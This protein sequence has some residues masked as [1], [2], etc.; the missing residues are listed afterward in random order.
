MISSKTGTPTMMS[1]L[2]PISLCNVAYKIISKVFCQ[3]LKSFLPNII[4]ETQLVFVS[5]RL[6]SNN[7]LI[8]QKMFHAL[9]INKSCKNK[10]MAI[11]T[12]MSKVYDWV[13]WPSIENL[14]RKFG[15]AEKWITWM[16]LCI[17]SVQYRVLINGQPKDR[18]IPHRGL[19]QDDP[20]SPYLF[21]LCR[22]A[23]IAN[24]TK[25]ESEKEISGLRIARGK[26][27][28]NPSPICIWY[29][30]FLQSK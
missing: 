6:I 17:K 21:I 22:E 3:R 10:Y 19:R 23:L 2:R 13:E 14:L 26:P 11:K 7:I 4:S 1:E 29:L 12:Y 25:A 15:F 27:I 20:L 8:A 5:G 18:I 28:D 9:R 16:M 30:V 24:I